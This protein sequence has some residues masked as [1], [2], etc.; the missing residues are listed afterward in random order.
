MAKVKEEG[1]EPSLK[2]FAG[3]RRRSKML[4]DHWATG[5]DR[6]QGGFVVAHVD[7][8]ACHSTDRKSTEQVGGH[9]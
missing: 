5:V 3:S 7:D 4:W 1:L 6:N 9:E 2:P 8:K